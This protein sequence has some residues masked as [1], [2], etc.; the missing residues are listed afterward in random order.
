MH[1]S[2]IATEKLAHGAHAAG[3]IRG[4]GETPAGSLRGASEG[5]RA[6]VA[7]KVASTCKTY[8]LHLRHL[9]DALSSPVLITCGDDA[10]VIMLGHESIH[11]LDEGFPKPPPSLRC[12]NSPQ[13]HKSRFH[14]SI[15]SAHVLLADAI[16][17]VC[18]SVTS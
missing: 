18:H 16:P 11:R 10:A 12:S 14:Y 3:V 1:G 9:L 17:I 4:R 8:L 13:L 5:G 6:H 7:V 2:L 15:S